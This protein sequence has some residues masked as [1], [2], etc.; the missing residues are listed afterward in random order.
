MKTSTV[1]NIEQVVKQR[2]KLLTI[3]ADDT[4]A[5][6]AVEM[7]ENQV[8]CLIV[9]DAQDKFAGIVTERDILAKVTTKSLAPDKLHVRDIMTT[10]V[11][12]CIMDTPVT[13]IEQLMAEHK[14]RHIPII[15]DG[16]PLGMVS[17]RDIVAHQLSHNQAMKN[18]AEQLAMLPAGLKS[19]DFEDVVALAINEVPKSFNADH[20]ALCIAQKDCQPVIYRKGN[21][22]VKETLLNTEKI[23]QLLQN[24][25]IVF[26]KASS[27][28]CSEVCGQCQ[29]KG[30]RP[31]GL[32]IPLGICDQLN[33]AAEAGS[34]SHGFLCMCWL[35]P[36]SIGSQES[37]LYK[38]SLLRDV[39]T[40]NLTNAKLFQHYQEARRVS[41]TDPLTGLGTRRVLE[42][43]LKAECARAAHYNRNFCVAIV[44]VDHFKEINDTAGH[45]AGD[46]T[47]KHL[48]NIMRNNLRMTDAIITRY[49]GDEFVI[50][51]LET[52]LTGAKVILERLRRY[53]NTITLPKVK[54]F[55]ITRAKSFTIAKVSAVTISC[56][57][58]E[59]D[60]G[61]PPD[62]AETILK[63]ADEAL[64]EAKN[65]GRNRVAVASCH[66]VLQK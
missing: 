7:A 33:A 61:P 34:R 66:V 46:N 2:D 58:A 16:V 39:L 64:Y 63:R 6:A 17:S 43:V 28:I 41:E 49:G 44:D 45:A 8:G 5:Q 3:R 19:L 20:A 10:D 18:A 56:G 52:R 53:V 26:G 29:I 25:R 62:T 37:L 60:K 14:I 12:S 35:N 65:S 1:R 36:D 24:R 54:S 4:V 32:V 31:S 59:W 48:A 13:K 47:L 15:E 27:A 23:G 55:T 57:L 51:M 50:L 21:P 22:P 40:V 11:V 9:L 38:A 30:D 42:D